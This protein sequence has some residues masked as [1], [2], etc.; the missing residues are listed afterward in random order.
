VV[1]KTYTR[2]LTNDAESAL[3]TFELIYGARLD[4]RMAFRDWD[5]I[6][7]G[8]VLIVG[9]SDDSLQPLL[10]THGPL[11]V[12]DLEATK[13]LLESA[14]AEITQPIESGPTG[15][16]LYARHADGSIVEYAQWTDALRERLIE[17]PRRHA[18]FSRSA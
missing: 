16:F 4:L 17:A 6:A 11:I 9:G 15:T 5:A 18:V 1:L 12:D 13:A 10:G 14:G 2:I 8:D 7:I 3:R